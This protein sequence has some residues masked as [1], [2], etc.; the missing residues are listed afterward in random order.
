[1]SSER[2]STEQGARLFRIEAGALYI[3]RDSVTK[4]SNKVVSGSDE[5]SKLIV[6]IRGCGRTAV[7]TARRHRDDLATATALVPIPLKRTARRAGRR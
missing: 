1:V 7:Q 3:E 6:R 4:T 5:T 2:Q